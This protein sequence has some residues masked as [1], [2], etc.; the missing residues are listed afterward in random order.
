MKY[1]FSKIL[2]WIY[3]FVLIPLNLSGHLFDL[4]NLVFFSKPLLMPL[5]IILFFQN[6]KAYASSLKVGVI[7]GLFFSW[8]GDLALMIE[9]VNS[10]FFMVGLVGFLIAHIN[11]II[12]FNKSKAKKTEESSLKNILIPVFGLFTLSFLILLWPH[13]GELRIPV[14]IYA[15]VLMLMGIFAVSRQPNKGFYLVLFGAILFV[16]SDS[17]LATNKFYSTFYLARVITMLTYTIAQLLI[18][19]GLS[20]NITSKN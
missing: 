5:L 20:K 9:S 19:L 17:V 2:L 13:L 12:V 14:I 8:I 16:I 4:P 11:Y 1:N 15:T 7:G 6:T 3:L 10:T 18:V